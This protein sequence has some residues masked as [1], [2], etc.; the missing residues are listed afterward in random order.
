MSDDTLNMSVRKFLKAVGVTSQQKIEEAVRSARDAGT[1][2]GAPLR[3]K[4][5]LTVEGIDLSH[6]VEGDIV[7]TDSE[8][9]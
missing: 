2:T 1:L 5:V 8:A 4:V 6:E 3:A 7:V 9:R